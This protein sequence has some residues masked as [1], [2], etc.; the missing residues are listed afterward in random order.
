M[1]GGEKDFYQILEVSKEAP[2][3]EIKESY[4]K[5]AFQ[6]HP[7]RNKENPAALERMK[8]INEAY[9][10]LSDPEKRGV[11]DRVRERYGSS[12]YDRFRDR[13]SEEDIFR[14][15]DI[16]QIFEEMTRGFGFRGFE[17]IFKETYGAGF[18]TFEF[19]RP[20][21]WGRGFIF[22]GPGFRRMGPTMPREPGAVLPGY[23][24]KFAATILKKMLGLKAPQQG[25]DLMD[26]ITIDPRLAQEGGKME[27]RH[28]RR[29]RDL[30]ITIPPAIREGQKI[31]LQGM[32]GEGKDG[33][34]PG[35]LYLQVK[36]KKSW[37]Q[38]IREFIK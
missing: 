22:L 13:Y 15:S 3:K 31:R 10:V 4:R 6:F 35:D 16:N 33:G 29:T 17:E 7:D 23:G 36:F 8:E 12:G 37:V 5:L 26:A 19:R 38:R 27:Y 21:V 18:R 14:G 28:W 11:Y 34:N 20:G 1:T 32:G 9:A 2:P 30:V 25:K 24:G